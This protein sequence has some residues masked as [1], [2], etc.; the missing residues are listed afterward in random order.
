ML[1]LNVMTSR[2]YLG[3]FL[4]SV[5]T[6]R[7]PYLGM[8]FLSVM[9]SAVPGDD[10][11]AERDDVT[12]VPGDVVVVERDDVTSA[13]PG[14]VLAERDDAVDEDKEAE[15]RRRDEHARVEAEPRE[16]DANLLAKI[17]PV[18]NARN[19]PYKQSSFVATGKL[20]KHRYNKQ[21]RKKPKRCLLTLF[22]DVVG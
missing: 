18:C 1:L 7:Q 5:M 15:E 22:V 11:L 6:S 4:L 21:L 9:T 3:M 13:V 19:N 16:V 10:V 2:Q 17:L 8:F 12:S 14:Y 20:V